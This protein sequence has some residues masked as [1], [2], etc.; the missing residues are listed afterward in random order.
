MRA[1]AVPTFYDGRIRINLEGRERTG[2]VA[3][4]AYER[5]CDEVE[6]AIRRCRDPRTGESVVE[7]VIR[8]RSD[9][10]W[11]AGGPEADLQVIWSRPLDAVEHPKAGTIGPFPF[12]RTG[13][14]RIDGFA[15]VAGPGIT[16]RELA[17]H[18]ALSV[19]A[20]VVA[21]AGGNADGLEA[22]PLPVLGDA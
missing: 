17:T 2:T 19:T 5:T 8:L 4:R 10:P 1:F 7:D 14:H 13:G 6:H 11:M 18:D 9:D 3:G 16:P 21:L 22:P 20:T 15:F 12:R